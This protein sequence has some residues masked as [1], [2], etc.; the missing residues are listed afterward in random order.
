MVRQIPRF[1]ILP[2]IVCLVAAVSL[3]ALS[4]AVVLRVSGLIDADHL[5]I[6]LPGK[7]VPSNTVW[8]CKPGMALDPCAGD[9]SST[10]VAADGSA[11]V[12]K[13]SAQAKPPIDCFYVYPTVSLQTSVNANLKIEAEERDV[14][15]A[16]ASRFSQVCDVYAPMY[17]QLT[18][19]AI[20]DP[21]SI[22]VTGAI[23]AYEGVW[24][25]FLDYLDHYNHGRG[26]V[27]IGHSQGAFLLSML[28]QAEVDTEPKVLT[29]LVSALLPGG[30]ITVQAGKDVGGDFRNIPAC[31]SVGQTGCVVAYSSYSSPPPEDSLFGR[32]DSPINPFHQDSPTKLQVL[33]VNP[34]APAGGRGELVPYLPTHGLSS[35]L[36]PGTTVQ[37]LD[38]TPFV[39]YPNEYSA[40]CQTKGQATWLQVDRTRA[41][42]DKRPQLSGLDNGRWGLHIVDLSLGLGNLVDLVRSE[43]ATYARQR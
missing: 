40:M 4:E 32:V 37:V 39:T 8:L 23:D 24:K 3:A 41:A 22:S 34:A 1:L 9:L 35:L 14:A 29:Q 26:I 13:A 18:K 27:F 15:K 10:V 43:S 25:A 33:C 20:D 19:A 7:P 21:Q 5:H 38:G 31:G 16:E 12:Q 42:G 11:V 30:N 2:L 17:P 28:I 6:S 36:G